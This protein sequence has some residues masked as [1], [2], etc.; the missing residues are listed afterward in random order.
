M[1][2]HPQPLG[3]I[4]ARADVWAIVLAGGDGL[5]L[6]GLTADSLGTTVP[7]QFCSLDG[8]PSLLEMAVTR[9]ERLVPTERIL[10]SVNAAHRRWWSD[11]LEM[12]PEANIVSQPANR[13][14]LAGL[15]LPLLEISAH[16]PNARIV[17]VP[18]D[19]FFRDEV[20]VETAARNALADLESRPESIVLLGME[21]EIIDH[22]LGWIV[23]DATAEEPRPVVAFAEKPDAAEA[24]RLLRQGALRIRLP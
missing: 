13:G 21:P 4:M 22:D 15:L 2:D 8:G 20:A 17:V 23:P 7:K 12:L 16:D 1:V 3:G 14:T 6:R 18:S 5:R 9:A 24:A 19:H 10:V 11:D